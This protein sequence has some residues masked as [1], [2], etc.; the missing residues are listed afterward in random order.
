MVKFDMDPYIKTIIDAFPEKITG[1]NST[2]AADH[3]FAVR[4][5]A[6]AHLLPKDQALA[7]YCTTAQLL[8]LSPVCRDIQTPAFLTTRVK[9]P[10]EDD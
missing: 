6:E 8:F 10:D 5:S 3:L 7:F 9:H 4:P 1:V 2:L